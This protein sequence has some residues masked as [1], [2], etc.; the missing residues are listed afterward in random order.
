LVWN[1]YRRTDA[2]VRPQA[3]TRFKTW[4]TLCGAPVEAVSGIDLAKVLH[5]R[6]SEDIEVSAMAMLLSGL[7]E[8][9]GDRSFTAQE[10]A[11]IPDGFEAANDA[12]DPRAVPV[13]TLLEDA[14][15]KPFPKGNLSANLVGKRLQMIADRPAQVDD[16]VL[17]IERTSNPKRGNTYK[18][19]SP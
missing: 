16:R 18:I 12:E 5:A 14:I 3:K 4:W 15:G 10:V 9:F 7:Q 8:T 11:D 1:K 2:S 19:K 13:R 17:M 6:E